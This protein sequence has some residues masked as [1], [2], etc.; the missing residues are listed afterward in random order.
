MVARTILLVGSSVVILLNSMS[1]KSPLIGIPAS[2]AFLYLCSVACG[3]V[4]F[5]T[6]KSY[7]RQVIGLIAFIILMALIGTVL[8]LLAI[9]TEKLSLISLIALGFA[10]CLFSLF[11]RRED[12][13]DTSDQLKSGKTL[14]IKPYLMLI[15][16]LVSVSFAFYALV[17]ARTGDGVKS[18]WVYIH[19]LFLPVFF[20]SSL[21][22]VIM[23][24]FTK[25]HVGLKLALICL[26]SFLA[27]SVFLLVWYP[28]RYGDTWSYLGNELFIDKTGT[29]YAYAWLYSQRFIADIIKYQGQYALV[30]FFRRMFSLDIYWVHVFFVPLLWSLLVPIVFYKLAESLSVK[31]SMRFSLL[32]ALGAGLF[33]TLVYW[34]AISATYSL[35]LLFLLCS[36]TLLIYWANSGAKRILFLSLLASIISLFTHPI[37]GVFALIV[38][39]LGVIIQ[40]RLHSILKL[41][42]VVLTFPMYPLVSHFQGASFWLTGLSNID[43]LLSFQFDMTTILLV[44]SFVGWLF[45]IKGKLIKGRNALMLFAFYAVVTV[46][47]FLSMYGMKDVPVPQRIPVIGDILLVP[48]VALGLLVSLSFLKDG[49]SLVNLNPIKKAASSRMV[50]TSAVC[51]LSALLL[52]SALYQAYPRQEITEV[53]PSAFEL[54]AILYIDSISEGQYVVLGDTNLAGLAGGFLG[55]DYSYGTGSVKGIFGIPEW[56]WWNMRLYQQMIN[57]PSLSVLETAM[58]KA[59]V[60]I[61]Y[62]VVSVREQYYEKI[63]QRTSEVLQPNKTFGEGRLTLFRYT[64]STLPITGNGPTITASYDNGPLTDVQTVYEYFSKSAVKYIARLT[65]H[66]SYNVTNYPTYWAFLEL[67]LNGANARPN[68]SSDVNTFIYIDG[69]KPE[70]T[71]EITWQA[72]DHYPNA[73]WKED[74]FKIGWQQATPTLYGFGKISPVVRK[75]GLYFAIS[76]NFTPYVGDYAFYYEFKTVSNISTNGFP[77][78]LVRWKSTGPVASV[79]V[80]YVDGS[81]SQVLPYGSESS[82]WT[83][84]AVRL[85]PD[86][87]VAYIIVGITN[88]PEQSVTGVRTLFVDYIIICAQA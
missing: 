68:D 70:D 45:S 64:S 10:V 8:I 86:R 83:V 77:W 30:V 57:N 25:I 53:Q 76:G 14:R 6:E 66:S 58:L 22:L 54:E 47:Y 2:V 46:N 61:G 73:V 39:F 55:I 65:G 80:K 24:F 18:V 23:L 37:T 11:K 9:F 88:T 71:L 69:L 35:G 12:V 52:T 42:A 85:E 75:E 43:N 62:F 19:P 28:G 32:C 3:E 59:G 48:F 40:S 27:H 1:T 51:L 72:N 78:V 44:F 63:V 29:F 74:S 81:E 15:P 20:L 16:F 7:L 31:K 38:F 34:G 17:L 21:S 26:Y 67:A 49:F 4:F 50:A 5:A 87:E 13:R 36:V 82:D 79:I 60:G 41:I 33:P 56:D 84:A